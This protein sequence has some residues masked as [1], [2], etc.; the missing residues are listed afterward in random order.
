MATKAGLKI[1]VSWAKIFDHFNILKRGM[2][3]NKQDEYSQSSILNILI[4]FL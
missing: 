3:Y 4:G 2:Q 1:S